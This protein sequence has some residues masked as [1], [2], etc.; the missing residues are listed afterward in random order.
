MPIPCK[1]YA[2][3]ITLVD[4]SVQGTKDQLI[5]IE[6]FSAWSHIEPNVGKCA[7]TGYCHGLQK[8]AKRDRDAALADLLSDVKLSGSRIPTLAQDSPHPDNYLGTAITASLDPHPQRRLALSTIKIACAAIGR[9]PLTAPAKLRALSFMTGAKLRHTHGLALYDTPT[10]AAM[11]AAI[12]GAV[13]RAAGLPRGFAGAGIQ[14][15]KEE[16]GMGVPSLMGDYAATGTAVAIEI[17][18]DHGPLGAL[19]MASVT[20]GA[21]RYRHWPLASALSTRGSL[22]CRMLALASMAQLKLSGMPVVWEGNEI[23]SSLE[24]FVLPPPITTFPL[25]APE[26]PPIAQVLAALTPLW[27]AGLTRW[28]DVLGHKGPAP[29]RPVDSAGGGAQAPTQQQPS[30]RAPAP[31]LPA[32]Y[33]LMESD[34]FR[35]RPELASTPGLPTALRYLRTLLSSATMA[36]FRSRRSLNASKH[37][38]HSF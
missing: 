32:L 34:V 12:A 4:G 20:R 2:D 1:V 38:V 5:K 31:A 28:S 25:P 8:Q 22:T 33:V 36:E 17:L 21:A 30:R 27:V 26:F 3:D 7:I 29:S 24:A 35:T 18:N 14:S 16:W 13:K 6:R 10:V 23:S 19:A 9:C 15:P 11:D 37:L